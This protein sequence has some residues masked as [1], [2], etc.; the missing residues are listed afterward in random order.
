MSR[1]RRCL[2]LST[3]SYRSASL[4]V[5]ERGTTGGYVAA[6]KAVEGREDLP[7]SDYLL[8]FHATLQ[9]GGRPSV[10]RTAAVGSY[11][12]WT[13][14]GR[15]SG[16]QRITFGDQHSADEASY[17]TL[18]AA[19]DD[20]LG[21]ILRRGGDPATFSAAVLGGNQLVIRQLTGEY[22]VRAPTLQPLHAQARER[23][24]RFKQSVAE[25]RPTTEILGQLRR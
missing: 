20:V 23:L 10:G 24:S 19:L 8:A 9:G 11:R 2:N 1:E 21:R 4:P 25:W 7:G 14:A 15:D 12:L 17:L 22:R 6:L 3:G 18:C 5:P 16:I 13:R